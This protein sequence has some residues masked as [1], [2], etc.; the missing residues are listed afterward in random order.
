[1]TFLPLVVAA[2]EV[3]GAAFSSLT[4]SLVWLPSSG[5]EGVLAG[6]MI[7]A[8]VTGLVDGFE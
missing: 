2:V 8:M 1:M 7:A 5:R 3:D 6:F 4:T